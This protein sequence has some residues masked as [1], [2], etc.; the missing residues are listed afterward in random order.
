MLEDKERAY[1]KRQKGKNLLTDKIEDEMD[2]IFYDINDQDSSEAKKS[3]SMQNGGSTLKSPMIDLEIEAQM[4]SE[5]SS[6]SEYD[7]YNYQ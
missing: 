2:A 6:E 5:E 1:H 7:E 3:D 4:S